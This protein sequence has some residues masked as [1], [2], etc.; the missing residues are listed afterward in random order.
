[1]LVGGNAKANLHVENGSLDVD[2]SPN[3]DINASSHASPHIFSDSTTISNAG[4]NEKLANHKMGIYNRLIKFYYILLLLNPIFL[5][6]DLTNICHIIS[7]GGSDPL[8][9]NECTSK[10]VEDDYFRR[11]VNLIVKASTFLSSSIT[12]NF[13][14]ALMFPAVRNETLYRS[15][16]K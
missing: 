11:D 3:T 5:I 8:E 9:Y 2:A 6:T 4:K 14:Y 12:Y 1:M 7:R 15:E 13:G 16:E 10:E